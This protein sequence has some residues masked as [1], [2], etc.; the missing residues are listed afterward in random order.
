MYFPFSGEMRYPM[1]MLNASRA[2]A[3]Q[4]STATRVSSDRQFSFKEYRLAYYTKLPR[5]EGGG[6]ERVSA[7]QVSLEAAR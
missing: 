3:S 2:V 6:C 5:V 1:A 4:I 7:H